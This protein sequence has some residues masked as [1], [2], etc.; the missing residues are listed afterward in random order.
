MCLAVAI[1][2]RAEGS[3]VE[4]RGGDVLALPHHR[5]GGGFRV[6]R[7]RIAPGDPAQCE[8]GHLEMAGSHGEGAA[9]QAEAI[10]RRCAVLR[11]KRRCRIDCSSYRGRYDLPGRG[12]V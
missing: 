12:S 9:F 3:P 1:R 10:E 7:H 8:A 11:A 5:E 2:F 4:D 6:E